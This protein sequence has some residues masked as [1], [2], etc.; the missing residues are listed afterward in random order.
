MCSGGAGNVIETG[1]VA[2]TPEAFAKRLRRDD[3]A[4]IASEVGGQSAWID[5]L[6]SALGHDVIVANARRLRMIYEN[7]SKS[8]E[9][10]A[11]Q[12]ARVA[13]MDVTLLHPIQHR[14]RST[15]TDLA[16]ARSRDMLF[17]TRT[18]LI[19]HVRG[20]LK[21][22]GAKLGSRSA[23]CFHG[24]VR[25]QIP[26]ELRRVLDPV[27]HTLECV[28]AQITALDKELDHPAGEET[29]A[30]EG[31][32]LVDLGTVEVEDALGHTIQVGQLGNRA[33]HAEGH[34]GLGDDAADLRVARDLLVGLV[35]LAHGVVHAPSHGLV[36]APWIGEKCTGPPAVW[37]ATPWCLE[38]K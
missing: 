29:V 34:L 24:W 38:G 18:S 36:H 23:S 33:L 4:R 10:D 14:Q 31:A 9:A 15:H 20:L 11:E 17:A 21:S 2:T 6:L 32:G 28:A 27:I 1:V 22:F 8:D 30:G 3:S 16:K 13:R 19:N 12:L 25:E 7:E 37:N 5:E 35:D 26:G